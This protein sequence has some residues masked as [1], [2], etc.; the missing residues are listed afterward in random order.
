MQRDSLIQHFGKPGYFVLRGKVQHFDEDFF[1]LGMTTYL[2]V[3]TKAVPIKPDGTFSE[4]FEVSNTQDIYLYLPGSRTIILSVCE[5]DTLTLNWDQ[6]ALLESL[7]IHSEDPVRNTQL[8]VQREIYQKHRVAL[9]ELRNE[10]HENKDTYTP[11]EKYER[12]NGRYNAVLE[13][14]LDHAD[15]GKADLDRILLA[16]YYNF[17]NLL[18]DQQLYPTF[19][20][21]AVLD[22]VPDYAVFK[23]DDPFPWYDESHFIHIPDFRDFYMAT[24]S[25]ANPYMG[26]KTINGGSEQVNFPITWYHRVRA[27]QG[28][29]IMQDWLMAQELT[30]YL[31]QTPFDYIKDAYT[32]FIEECK[33]PF[34]KS[35]TEQLYARMQ[36]IY[37]GR[38]APP[39][40]L[41]NEAGQAVS[42]ADFKGKVVYIDFWGV[43]CAPCMYDIQHYVPK[44]HE[45][46]KDKD[47]VFVNICVDVGEAQWKA[48]L[49][50]Q[51]LHG[52]N[53]IAEGWSRHPVC[54][55]YNVHAIPQY[56]LINRDGTIANNNPQRPGQL[57]ARL[58]NNQIDEA[59]AK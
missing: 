3:V 53:L 47:V 48:A 56:I 58:G 35:E 27:S 15:S 44:V 55:A 11:A 54:Q 26:T 45:Y 33:T 20:L 9:I 37:P 40:T 39:F 28:S 22:T 7:S 34:F 24:T 32:L 5:N 14:V 2:D 36:N 59:L 41:K 42:L 19:R 21:R 12:I 52:V 16:Q 43:Y 29:D 38:E 30:R 25:K 49:K 50:Q 18:I 13:T 8:Q 17:T 31:R 1:E 6:H 4:Q 46:Y 23:L 57:T 51:E 10:L